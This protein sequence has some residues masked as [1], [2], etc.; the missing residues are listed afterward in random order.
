[1]SCARSLCYSP[2]VSKVAAKRCSELNE[3]GAPMEGAIKGQSTPRV[4]AA[5]YGSVV[6]GGRPCC[7]ERGQP[8]AAVTPLRFR[9]HDCN[10]TGP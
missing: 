10:G 2:R 9:V 6:R 3:D 4:D 7:N 1:M 8:P 5:C